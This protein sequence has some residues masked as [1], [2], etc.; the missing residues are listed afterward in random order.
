MPVEWSGHGREITCRLRPYMSLQP[1]GFV[2]AIGFAALMLAVPMLSV[3]GRVALWGLLP[4]AVLAVASLWLALRRSWRM[5]ETMET[6]RLTR[7]AVHLT[8]HDPGRID[9]E[10]RANPYWVRLQLYPDPVTDYLTLTDGRREVE[11]GAFLTPSERRALR[12]DIERILA[13]LRAV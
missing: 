10:W 4:F 6:L 7:D 3:L 1:K 2:W 12:S 8:R 13:E 9:R 11:L 5:G